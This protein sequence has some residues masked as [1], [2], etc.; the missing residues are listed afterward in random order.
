MVVSRVIVSSR[1][2]YCNSLYHNIALKDILK[3]Q[4]VQTCLARVV[5]RSPRFS[6]PL[7]LLKSLHWFPVRYHIIFKIC[8][9]TYQALLSKHPA[10]LHLLLTP[11]VKTNVETRAFSVAAPTLWN[12]LPVGV[13][14][15]GNITTFRRKLKT[16]LLKL[17]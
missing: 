13:K 15:V 8:T 10:Y 4:R 16:H 11:S 14:S 12:P 3:L 5:T 1:L 6:H 9:I 2:D 7:P 17:A